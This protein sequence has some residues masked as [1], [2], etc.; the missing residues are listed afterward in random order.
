MFW[1]TDELRQGVHSFN[2]ER[3]D[4][5]DLHGTKA[6]KLYECQTRRLE[7][8]KWSEYAHRVHYDPTLLYHRDF[9]IAW[10]LECL[11]EGYE[12]YPGSQDRPMRYLV[13]VSSAHL[14]DKVTNI[15]RIIFEISANRNGSWLKPGFEVSLV[16]LS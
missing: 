10:P 14:D 1:V 12:S 6:R 16:N 13:S 7:G 2:K 4:L 8:G 11:L 15:S 3:S 5:I 9:W